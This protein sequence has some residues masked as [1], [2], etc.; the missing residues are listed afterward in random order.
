MKKLVAPSGEWLS[1]HFFY[2]PYRIGYQWFQNQC[3]NDKNFNKILPE[4]SFY[5]E[6]CSGN[7][8]WILEKA[9]QYPERQWIACE[10][11]LDRAKKIERKRARLEVDNLRILCADIHHVLDRLPAQCFSHLW[12]NFPDPWPKTRHE[13]HRL[14]S[15]LFFDS[16]EPRMQKGAPFELATDAMPL[17]EACRSQLQARGWAL[18]VDCAPLPTEYGES[19]F[20]CLWEEKGC[21][22][23]WCQARWS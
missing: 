18:T 6:L 3:L 17:L 4:Q 12:V 10:R 9:Q 1:R 7:G 21:C 19:Y 23:Y 5:V 16:L 2:Q 11:R 15:P 14:F 8:A 13:K 22:L 20:S